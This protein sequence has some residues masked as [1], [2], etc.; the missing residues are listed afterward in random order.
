V[1]GGRQLPMKAWGLVFDPSPHRLLVGGALSRLRPG[2]L[3]RVG[4]PLALREIDVPEA[5]GPDWVL[6]EPRFVG[7]CGSDLMQA[8]LK[9][10][11]DNP[12]SGLIS[13]PHVM[14]HEIVAEAVADGSWVVV[15]PWLGCLARGRECCPSCAQGLPA[16][17]H[18]AGQPVVAGVTG[19]GMHLGNVRGL[20]GGFASAILAHRSQSHPLPEG[21]EPR[22]AVLADPLAVG[23]HAVD[24]S[25]Y[26]GEGVA[27]VLGAGTIGLCAAAALRARHSGAEVLVTAA[28]PHLAERVREL[29]AT[30]I[31]TRSQAVT[32]A[33]ARR[34][35]ARQVR[36][37]LGP[38][39]LVGGGASV[40]IDAVGSA[41]TGEVALRAVRPRGRVVRV[42][43]GRAA[44]LQATLAYYKEVEVVGSNGS[45]AGDLERA[46]ALLAAGTIPYAAWL[47]H[48]FPLAAWRRAFETAGRPG[49]TGA[50]KVTLQ[51]AGID[52]EVRC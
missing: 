48:S 26:G 21:L 50:V 2:S 49:R 52:E 34:T 3:A 39:W 47:T 8:Q 18:H 35:G 51:P 22:A 15:D 38:P 44:R 13:F 19:G 6:L 10:D 45:R 14:G 46:L 31:G 23:L 24:R 11:R 1:V 28:W 5:F 17:C 30:P 4:S 12:L 29:G 16:L 42:G 7:I 27:L 9:A 33:V 40:V 25:G 43:V 20:P 41:E 32:E 36:P 37:W